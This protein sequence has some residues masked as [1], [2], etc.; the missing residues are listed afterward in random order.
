[1]FGVG[2]VLAEVY[3]LRNVFDSECSSDREYLAT[4]DR[5]VGPFP[6]DY[7][8]E[9]EKQCPGTFAFRERVTVLYPPL[10]TTLLH[11][12]HVNPIIRIER[13]LP[14]SVRPPYVI[15]PDSADKATG[16]RPR[17]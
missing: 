16:P 9:I 17:S 12:S 13:S 10:G 14:L 6:R 8:A 7:A 4:I 1:M 5:V 11:E 15:L 3:V 2:C